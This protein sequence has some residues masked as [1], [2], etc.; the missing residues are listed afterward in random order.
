MLTI[1]F[2]VLNLLCVVAFPYSASGL[3]CASIAV[4]FL[5]F[6]N[7]ILSVGWLLVV[8]F[9][10]TSSCSLRVSYR[11]RCVQ[12]I[13]VA[14]YYSSVVCCG[15]KGE[16]RALVS[17]SWSWGSHNDDAWRQ[18]RSAL[19]L[20]RVDGKNDRLLLHVGCPHTAAKLMIAGL[21]GAIMFGH[22]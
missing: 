2:L 20:E 4:G 16:Q 6:F 8:A 9:Y 12:F 22:V 10:N 14:P 21:C 13:F 1:I 17:I 7:L 5:L 11:Q 15:A 18:S 3:L 19:G